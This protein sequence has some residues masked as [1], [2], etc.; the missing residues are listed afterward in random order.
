MVD[1]YIYTTNQIPHARDIWQ[2]NQNCVEISLTEGT[3]AFFAVRVPFIPSF[4]SG[5]FTRT[6]TGEMGRIRLVVGRQIRFINDLVTIKNIGSDSSATI[7]LRFLAQP[8]HDQPYCAIKVVFVGKVFCPNSTY[9]NEAKDLAIRLWRQFYSHFPLEDPFNYPLLPVTEVE[10]GQNGQEFVDPRVQFEQQYLWPIACERIKLSNLVEIRKYVDRDP[11]I[12]DP[13]S[14]VGSY[15]HPF[16]PALDFSAMGRFLETLARQTQRCAV[17]VSLRPTSLFNG[18]L[19]KDVILHLNQYLRLLEQQ[20]EK[21]Q[22]TGKKRWLARYRQERFETIYR[23]YEPFIKQ[24][25]HLF[26][27]K[28]QIVGEH[29]APMDLVEALGSELMDNTGQEVYFWQRVSPRTDKEL[30][31][32]KKNFAFLEHRRWG[33]TNSKPETSRLPFLVTAY[34]AAGAFRLPIPPESG[35][36]PGLVVK[37]EPFV[38]PSKVVDNQTE[39]RIKEPSVSLGQIIHRGTETDVE[40]NLS[41]DD[42]KRH[43]LVVG[44]T[45][46]G[47]TTTYLHLLVQ[48]Q[49][50]H[51]IPF[52]VIY[53]IDKPDYRILMW[54]ERVKEN[55]LIFTLGDETTSPF[56]FNPFA[57]P[58]GILLKTHTS[59]LMRCFMAA[60]SMWDPLPAVYRAALRKVYSDRGWNVDRDKGCY[61]ANAFPIMRDFYEAILELAPKLTEEYGEEVRGNIRQASEIRVRDLLQ[62]TGS[63]LNVRADE[64]LWEEILTRPTVMELGRVGSTEDT[65]LIMGFLLTCLSARLVSRQKSLKREQLKE[66]PLQYEFQHFTLI[67]EAHR[68]MSAPTGPSSEFLADPRA[69]G[70]EDFSN[71]L[72]EVRGYGEGILIS[73]QIPTNLVAGA[74]GNTYLK[75]MH[76]LEDQNS[77]D[78]FCDILN[79]NRRQREY[80]RTLRPGQAIVRS[81]AGRPVLVQVAPYKCQS[82]NEITFLLSD[83]SDEAVHSFMDGRIVIPEP[84][85][86]GLKERPWGDACEFCLISEC[87]YYDEIRSL[88]Q[89]LERKENLKVFEPLFQAMSEDKPVNWDVLVSICNHFIGPS[90]DHKAKAYCFLARWIFEVGLDENPHLWR[91][92]E[93]FGEAYNGE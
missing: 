46:S 93:Q 48:L 51:K 21:E 39:I 5:D 50:Q 18:E 80:A 53:P 83:T 81:P 27:I 43:A 25:Q 6:A 86:L 11:Q 29:E 33:A 66:R 62:N 79:L 15:P 20:E 8:K 7:D 24:H 65:A 69:K 74:I 40:F 16:R 70:G 26:S 75:V 17:S 35:Y 91:V 10:L 49:A 30:D 44:A 77:F 84:D 19:T 82:K 92:L 88:D 56:R 36:L 73:E 90:P 71:I 32:A 85:G 72:A 68:L 67:E 52:L 60:F 76:W 28:I 14:T 63:I 3:H 13:E 45:G 42:L 58:P 64:T 47:K 78:L 2:D 22:E 31:V 23:V 61:D 89:V 54:D 12:A 38:L 37:D 87:S 4:L 1:P 59:R 57:V 55:L 9:P 34:E 41:V